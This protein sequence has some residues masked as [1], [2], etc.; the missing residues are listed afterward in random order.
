MLA[1]IQEAVNTLKSSKNVLAFSGAGIS[2]ESGIPTFRSDGGLWN[3]YDPELFHIS[4]FINHPEES[5][6]LIKKLFYDL[7]VDA[8][9][10]PAHLAVAELEKMGFVKAVV[11]Q[12]I[13]N[14]HQAAGS[15]VVHEFHGTTKSVVCMQCGQFF[16][17]DEVNIETMP[18]RCKK[19]WGL[20]KP[21]FVFFD[22]QIPRDVYQKSAAAAAA[23]DAVLIIGTMGAVPPAAY[24]PVAAKQHG[25][26]IIEVN[27]EPSLYTAEITDIFLQEKAGVIMPQLIEALKAEIGLN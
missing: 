17:T 10:N 4:Y 16:L 25:A 14:L 23:A 21:N 24:L 1:K 26:T 9:P 12:N 19:C 7:L 22:E 11:T 18:P 2:V 3:T 15:Q 27:P 6:A 8:K 5:W 13:D 20:L